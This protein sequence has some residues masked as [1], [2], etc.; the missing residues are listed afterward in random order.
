MDM[1]AG[2]IIVRI[3]FDKVGGETDRAIACLVHNPKAY[4]IS[5]TGVEDDCLGWIDCNSQAFVCLVELVINGLMQYVGKFVL[6]FYLENIETQ[7]TFIKG[8]LLYINRD[9]G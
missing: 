6:V 9:T 4:I 2:F 7:R 5:C 3:V 1:P 8:R